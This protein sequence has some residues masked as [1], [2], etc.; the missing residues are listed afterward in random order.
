[1]MR[2]VLMESWG[3]GMHAP[4]RR[5]AAVGVTGLQE[6]ARAQRVL[7]LHDHSAGGARWAY[8]AAQRIQRSANLLRFLPASHSFQ[9]RQ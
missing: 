8:L 4:S 7:L 1:M 2:W 6:P 9:R 3:C 5:G